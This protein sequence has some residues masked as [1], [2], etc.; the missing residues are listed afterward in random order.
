MTASYARVQTPRLS[1]MQHFAVAALTLGG[2]LAAAMTADAA[3]ASVLRDI[4]LLALTVNFGTMAAAMGGISGYA[5]RSFAQH[6]NS[7]RHLQD[8]ALPAQ[9]WWNKE[10]GPR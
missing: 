4:P 3:T 2:G 9:G 1:L 10:Q 5:E 6:N 8:W 7:L